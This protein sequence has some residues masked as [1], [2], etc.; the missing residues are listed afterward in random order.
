MRTK[1]GL[2]PRRAK[3][4]IGS[5]DP[6]RRLLPIAHFNQ[7]AGV[8]QYVNSMWEMQ[9][10]PYGGDAINSD[11]DGPLGPG[12]PPLGPF[13]ELETSSPAAERRPGEKLTHRHRTLHFRGDAEKLDR[14]ARPVLG[15]TTAEIAAALP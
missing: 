1:I 4:V 10:D 5:C 8:T 15:A 9:T 14:I 11:N 2:S 12:K 7:P 3:G 6:A 13:Y